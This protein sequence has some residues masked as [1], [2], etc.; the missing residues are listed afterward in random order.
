VSHT[1]HIHHTI[2]KIAIKLLL[3]MNLPWSLSHEQQYFV[4]WAKSKYNSSNMLSCALNLGWTITL[5]WW[6]FLVSWQMCA[7]KQCLLRASIKINASFL[8]AQMLK[9][10]LSFFLSTLLQDFMVSMSEVRK[11]QNSILHLWN[12]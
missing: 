9:H 8:L 2:L 4:V 1:R 7:S 3:R 5:V 6:S 10:Q 11:I 12:T